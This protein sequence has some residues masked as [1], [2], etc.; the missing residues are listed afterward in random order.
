MVV[1]VGAAVVVRAAVWPLLGVERM[2]GT[3]Q[4]CSHE[5]ADGS[6]LPKANTTAEEVGN[7]A[8][9]GKENKGKGKKIKT[10]FQTQCKEEE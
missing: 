3:E 5:M 6:G 8:P 10:R 9:G 2:V 4:K 7:D 1:V